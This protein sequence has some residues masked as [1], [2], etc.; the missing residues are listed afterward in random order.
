[1][2]FFD[3]QPG[4]VEADRRVLRKIEGEWRRLGAPIADLLRPGIAPE[5]VDD[6][7]R[8][9]GLSVPPELKVLWD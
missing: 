9:H 3:D 6:L 7:F 5:A 8:P 1:L 2:G 4:L